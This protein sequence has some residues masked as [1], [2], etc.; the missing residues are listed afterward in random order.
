[1]PR[2]RRGRRQRAE[3]FPGPLAPPYLVFG[4]YWTTFGLRAARWRRCR[5]TAHSR[6]LE[7]PH[8]GSPPSSAARPTSPSVERD[9][10]ERPCEDTNAIPSGFSW[11]KIAKQCQFGYSTMQ[12]PALKWRARSLARSRSLRL[13][14]RMRSSYAPHP[15][16]LRWLLVSDQHPA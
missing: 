2:S 6:A 4:P 14:P 16:F 13:T 5:R 8:F 10:R 9:F 1:V 7:Q 3:H 12:P 11:S 15:P